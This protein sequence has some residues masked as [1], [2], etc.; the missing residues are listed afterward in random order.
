M[1]MK[2]LTSSTI[3]ALAIS[4]P[5][6]VQAMEDDCES[7]HFHTH[8][9]TTQIIVVDHSN[10]SPCKLQVQDVVDNMLQANHVIQI[11]TPV[12]KEI[13]EY[14]VSPRTWGESVWSY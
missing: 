2:L 7:T 12:T 4:L 14:M 8:R 13:I 1:K 5:Q 10:K 6:K 11:V 3:V 9:R